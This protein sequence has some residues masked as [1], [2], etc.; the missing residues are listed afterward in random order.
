MKLYWRKVG[1]E[2][3]TTDVPLRGETHRDRHM[4]RR[5][6]TERRKPYHVTTEAEIGVT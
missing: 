3:H 2:S 1:P 6:A 5:A 4:E